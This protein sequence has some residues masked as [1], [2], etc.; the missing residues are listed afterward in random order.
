MPKNALVLS[1][2][3]LA[4]GA[5]TWAEG[6][7]YV[8]VSSQPAGAAILVDGDDS[9]LTTPARL[10]LGGVLGSSHEITLRKVGY[11]PE[12]RAVYHYTTSSF[13]RWI[14]GASAPGVW[15]SPL[16][17]TPGDFLFPFAVTWQY[18]P[19]E[20]YVKLYPEDEIAPGGAVAPATA[21]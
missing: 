10:E 1:L 19:A 4:A 12:T 2:L 9:G 13:A 21:N 5:C 18:V 15:S 6:D 3:A 8:L 11:H 16:F 20:L 17:W 7:P 14:D